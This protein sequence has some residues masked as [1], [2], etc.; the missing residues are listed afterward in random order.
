M[1]TSPYSLDL[2][3]KVIRYLE[4]GKSQRQA[5]TVFGISKTTVNIW[6]V[7]YKREGNLS[8][9]KRLGSKASIHPEE[10]IK[11]VNDNSNATS[12]DI[13]KQFSISPSGVRYWLKKLNFSYKKKPLPTWKR[14]KKRDLGI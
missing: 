4:S 7:R 11:Y 2:R 3:K 12:A 14:M 1:S 5:S 13:S 8:P 6:Y 10:F 9:R